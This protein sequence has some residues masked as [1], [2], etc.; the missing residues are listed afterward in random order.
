MM[1]R[2]ASESSDTIGARD[3]APES[4]GAPTLGMLVALFCA[5]LAFTALPVLLHPWPPMSDYINHLARMQVIATVN[6]DP[7]LARFYEIDWQ[8]LPNL[9]EDLIVPPL[10][11]LMSIYAAGQTYTILSFV[12]IAAGTVVLHRALFHRWSAL[13][14][15]AFPFL[16]NNV[17]LVGTMNYVFGIGLALWALATWAW[18]RERS[19]PLRLL[20]SMLFVIGLFFCHLFAVGV[21]GIGLLA[22]ELN[23]LWSGLRRPGARGALLLDFVATGLPFVPVLPMLMMSPTWGLRQ[24]YTYEIPGKAEGLAY[25]IEVYS[26]GAAFFFTAAI[27]F[28]IGWAMRDRALRFH[29]VGIALVVI[30]VAVFM[31]LPR[32][33]FETYMADQRLPISLAFM[34]IACFDLDMRE[35]IVRRGFAVVLLV[36]L[37]IRVAE[38]EDMW[39]SLSAGTESF[40]KSVEQ[41]DRGSKVLV[42]YAD[43]DG[44]DD[45]HDFG[46]VHA[47]S[48]AVIERSALVT[49][50]FTVIGKQI[51]HARPE[52]RGRVDD[53]DGTPPLIGELVHQAK[54]GGDGRDQYWRHWLSDYDYLYVLFVDGNF[55]NPDPEHL[56]TLFTGER[57]VLYHIDTSQVADARKAAK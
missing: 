45:V 18:L 56:T 37:G 48:M 40:K 8:I 22:F 51:M 57:F 38:V 6:T 54:S 7:D 3:T 15:I 46:I 43:P 11:H 2:L 31:A 30:G 55:E 24:T 4:R 29:A 26:H 49:S 32:V 35:R 41:I 27:A 47:P 14:L 33:I 5:L 16:Y 9:M 17:F 34:L 42:A 20:V 44:G 10:T 25:I 28:A 52:F 53:V 36:M 21:Y 50:N 1:D 39:S 12:L 23:R 13:P 19:L